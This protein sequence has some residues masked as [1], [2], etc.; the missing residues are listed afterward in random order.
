MKIIAVLVDEKP[1]N[2]DECPFC[3]EDWTRWCGFGDKCCLYYQGYCTR[4]T[5]PFE[6]GSDDTD[7]SFEE[8]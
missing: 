6:Y 2:A 5:A 4:L 7:V 1:K 3:T 8:D